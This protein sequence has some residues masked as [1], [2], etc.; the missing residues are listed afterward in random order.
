MIQRVEH[1]W[2]CLLTILGLHDLLN[3]IFLDLLVISEGMAFTVEQFFVIDHT[4]DE[5][6]VPVV[7]IHL[8]DIVTT[9]H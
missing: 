4:P 7:S 6:K 1:E 9:C 5:S 2:V 8:D 3:W